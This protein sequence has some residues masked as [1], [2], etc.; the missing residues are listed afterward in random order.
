MIVEYSPHHP[1]NQSEILN[2]IEIKLRRSDSEEAAW[3]NYC[4]LSAIESNLLTE[5]HR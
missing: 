2:S 1:I 5:Q 4:H 3:H